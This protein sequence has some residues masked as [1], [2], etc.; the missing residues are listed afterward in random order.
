[1]AAPEHKMA[2][3]W[4]Y[5]KTMIIVGVIAA[6]LIVGLFYLL[7]RASRGGTGMPPPH[8]AVAIRPGSA[9][10]D[11][12]SKKIAL[13]EPEADQ[14]RRALGD[15]VMTLHTTVRNFTGRTLSG[16]ELRAAVVDHQGKAV[17]ERTVVAIPTVERPELAPNK[18]LAV[19]VLLDGMSDT[20]DRAN[21]KFEITGFNLK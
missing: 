16:L 11:Q 14:A 8:L 20:D 19:N 17:K 4:S 2:D 9:E 18:T 7:K 13:D 12:Y 3:S 10:W 1:M 6:V 21:I 5:R 15:I